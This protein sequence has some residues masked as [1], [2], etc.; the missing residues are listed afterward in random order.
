V[1]DGVALLVHDVIK[2]ELGGG[3][4]PSKYIGAHAAWLRL[5]VIAHNVRAA[6]KRLAPRPGQLTQDRRRG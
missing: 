5:A 3:V 1:V 4:W 2:Y 6:R